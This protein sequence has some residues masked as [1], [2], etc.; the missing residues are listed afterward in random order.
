MTKAQAIQRIK[1]VLGIPITRTDDPRHP[2]SVL[3]YDLYEAMKDI[4]LDSEDYI[5]QK[6]LRLLANQYEY[7]CPYDC[8]RIK[9]VQH[10]YNYR[11]R[12]LDYEPLAELT[13]FLDTSWTTIIPRK[14]AKTPGTHRAAHY[15]G[16]ATVASIAKPPVLIDYA[17]CYGITDTG[18]EIDQYDIVFDLTD[19]NAYGFINYIESMDWKVGDGE[20]GQACTAVT[21]TSVTDT[22]TNFITAGV[23]YGDIISH[24]D[25]KSWGVIHTVST[26]T[27][28]FSILHG[29]GTFVAGDTYSIG[30]GNKITMT[31]YALKRDVKEDMRGG[32][33]NVWDI[34]TVASAITGT[35]LATSFTATTPDDIADVEV[36]HV[37]YS[38]TSDGIRT[39]AEVTVVDTTTGII[40][41]YPR[42][43]H[44][45]PE[46]NQTATITTVPTYIP[47]DAQTATIVSGDEYRIEDRFA[48]VDGLVIRPVPSTT[49]VAGVESLRM[50]YYPLP[51]QPI[52]DNDPIAYNHS[53]H[54]ATITNMLERAKAREEG[55]MNSY[56]EE[57]EKARL[58]R[59]EY[60][61]GEIGNTYVR[62]RKRMAASTSIMYTDI[63]N[64]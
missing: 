31:N 14:Y 30:T 38:Q 59:I 60:N 9:L 62:P 2:D 6:T 26:N 23:T 13:H 18:E 19:Y 12:D 42:W 28:T 64:I 46:P 40:T 3:E 35:Y 51:P 61:E 56:I 49:D 55:R 1:E 47:A 50:W 58:R 24:D 33:D 21:D 5:A 15:S 44:G 36:G 27:V 8:M 7:S 25:S 54:Q 10:I 63:T 34:T 57:L 52:H 11:W 45:P 32:E 16:Q 53:Y 22:G 20:G 17:A 29:T 41:I 48:T 37:I 39:G 4:I 43:S